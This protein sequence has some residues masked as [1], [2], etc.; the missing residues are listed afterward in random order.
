[1]VF[2]SPCGP[3]HGNQCSALLQKG[4]DQLE[5]WCRPPKSTGDDGAKRSLWLLHILNPAMEY[6]DPFEPQGAN[7]VFDK[8][9][10]FST[11]LHQLNLKLRTTDLEGDGGKPRS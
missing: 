1:M 11:C 7:E 9:D 5:Q 10:L 2:L 4:R 3:E 6:G 8:G